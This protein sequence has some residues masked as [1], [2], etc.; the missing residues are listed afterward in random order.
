[1]K[2]RKP[3]STI[4]YNSHDFL[5]MKCEDLIKNHVIS[6]YCFIHHFKESDENKNHF[7][8]FMI[9]NGQVDTMDIQLFFREFD[10]KK[11][12]KPLGC[13]DFHSSNSDDWILYNQHFAPYLASKGESREFQYLKENFEFSCQDTFDYYYHHAFYA[14]DWS[15]DNQITQHLNSGK[16]P[17]ELVNCGLVSWKQSN[18]LLSYARLRNGYSYTCERNGRK[19]HEN[20]EFSN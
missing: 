11:P 1:M 12:N 13:I 19:N 4:S 17:A 5:K 15:K 7:H 8:V 14:S 3:I 18:A 10:P 16:S 20:N 6:F 2:T 9:P